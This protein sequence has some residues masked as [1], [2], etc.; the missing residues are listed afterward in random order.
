MKAYELIAD[1]KNWRKG[2][3]AYD[4]HGKSCWWN[5]PEAV[6][7]CAGGAIRRCYDGVEFKEKGQL[8]RDEVVKLGFETVAKWNDAEA[9]T[10]EEVITTL[11]KVEDG[12]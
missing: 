1:P 2:G 5:D 12:S 7:F 3:Y 11:K 4:A 9:T 6:C 10:H 8:L